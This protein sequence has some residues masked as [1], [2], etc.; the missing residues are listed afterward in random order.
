[1]NNRAIPRPSQAPT[2]VHM[3]DKIVIQ[4]IIIFQFILN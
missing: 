4:I 2:D 1:M 3:Q